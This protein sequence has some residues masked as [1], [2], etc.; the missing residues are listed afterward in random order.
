[1]KKSVKVILIV[2]GILIIGLPLLIA[3]IGS[4]MVPKLMSNVSAKAC[5]AEI[6]GTV[7]GKSCMFEDLDG[8][9]MNVR[10]SNLED[11]NGVNYCTD[12]YFDRNNDS[13]R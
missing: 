6:G 9:K 2:V 11:Y 3:I 4:V 7:Y 5:C 12:E 1:M 13:A 10:L 8:K